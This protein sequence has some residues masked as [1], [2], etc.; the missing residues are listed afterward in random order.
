[1]ELRND[2]DDASSG[3][4]CAR[5][6]H[7]L[8]FGIRWTQAAFASYLRCDYWRKC[9]AMA[10]K[11]R[12]IRIGNSQGVRIPKPLL[13]QSGITGAVELEVEDN[14]IVIHAVIQ[15][16]QSWEKE[17]AAMAEQ[18]DDQLIDPGVPASDWDTEEWQWE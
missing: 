17:F 14:K 6:D 1:M 3:T 12:I 11:T 16:R 7:G 4:S 2:R 10:V 8:L 5:V 13:E 15:P 9:R 18:G